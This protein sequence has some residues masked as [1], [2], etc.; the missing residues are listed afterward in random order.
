MSQR[1][2]ISLATITIALLPVSYCR[3]THP[4]PVSQLVI[5]WNG[6]GSGSSDNADERAATEALMQINR[7]QS[8]LSR[9]MLALQRDFETSTDYQNALSAAQQAHA[10]L[11]AIRAAALSKLHASNEYK[12]AQLEIWNAQ[13]KLDGDDGKHT[14]ELAALL[15]Q[16]RAALTS[17]DTDLLEN[18]K[19]IRQA[20][21]KLIDSVAQLSA[22]RRSFA[23]SI[24]FNPQWREAHTQL[25]EARSRLASVGN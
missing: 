6:S 2:L 7:A 23:D 10:E 18:D 4:A 24:R 17:L 1:G 21:F 8:Q 11:L 14:T 13:Q 19:T 9:A 22:I 5:N 12:A 20:R 3:A 16:R 25:E 15:L